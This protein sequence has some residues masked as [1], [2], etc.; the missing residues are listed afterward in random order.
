MSE[1]RPR[2]QPVM[3][4]PDGSVV[5]TPTQM[6]QQI[7][8]LA[9]AVRDLKGAVDPAVSELRHDLGDHET[10]IRDLE[11]RRYVSPAVVGAALTFAVAVLGV[12]IAFLTLYHGK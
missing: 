12:L 1:P 3:P 7:G 10:R 4:I 9:S 5:I 11:K 2:P 6:Y 8:D